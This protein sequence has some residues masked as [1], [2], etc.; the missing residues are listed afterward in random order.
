MQHFT[1]F[2]FV[3]DCQILLVPRNFDGIFLRGLFSFGKPGIAKRRLAEPGDGGLIRS[4]GGW[5]EVKKI[6]FL[7]VRT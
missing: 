3:S 7:E 6:W 1:N 5:S 4:L 2:E